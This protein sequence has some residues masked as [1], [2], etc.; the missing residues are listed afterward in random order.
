MI[1]LKISIDDI[2]SDPDFQFLLDA[3]AGESA[4]NG[5][6]PAI[7]TMDNYR[8]LENLGMIHVFAAHHSDRLI[9]FLCLMLTLV[10]HYNAVI[11]STESFFVDKDHRKTGA[12]LAL[13]K[14]AERFAKG[15]GAAGMFVSTPFGSKLADVMSAMPSYRETNRVFFRS[16]TDV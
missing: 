15:A 10:P 8:K 3:Y 2:S 11:G 14:E 7:P 6:P 4:I 1:I 13:L 9:G 16:I 12:G 5:M